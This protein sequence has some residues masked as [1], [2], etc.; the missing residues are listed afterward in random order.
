MSLD[1]SSTEVKEIHAPQLTRLGARCCPVTVM[2]LPNLRV[3]HL[4]ERSVSSLVAKGLPEWHGCI[5]EIRFDMMRDNGGMRFFLDYPM[6]HT[7]HVS[8]F[9]G[10]GHEQ[11]LEASHTLTSLDATGMSFS[12]KEISALFPNL[13][14]L[15][16]PAVTV[17]GGIRLKLPQL[18]KLDARLQQVWFNDLELE[19]VVQHSPSLTWLD[20]SGCYV[21]EV[22]LVMAAQKLPLRTVRK[23]LSRVP[24]LELRPLV[25]H[26]VI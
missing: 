5:E 20:V 17:R 2:D 10:D 11:L 16:L 21:S 26:V 25:K 22:A 8:R 14:E 6:L 15:Y 7:L 4:K 18:V 9:S 3:L 1:I 23:L 13:R 24:L 19:S 12:P